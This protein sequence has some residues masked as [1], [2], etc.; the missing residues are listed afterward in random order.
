[1]PGHSDIVSTMSVNPSGRLLATG[2]WDRT[3]RIWSLDDFKE[4]TSGKLVTG[5]AS[6]AWSEKKDIV[7]TADFSGSIISWFL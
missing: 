5:I 3:L 4:I 1:M 7:Y 6:L 2:S